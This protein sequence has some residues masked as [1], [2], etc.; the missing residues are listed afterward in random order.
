MGGFVYVKL[1]ESEWYPVVGL[2]TEPGSFD[3]GWG[4]EMPDEVVADFQ[5]RFDEFDRL[6]NDL[7]VWLK[8]QYAAY[9][10]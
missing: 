7:R 4:I 9:P 6:Q 8:R 10:K 1:N 5:R 2:D 3:V